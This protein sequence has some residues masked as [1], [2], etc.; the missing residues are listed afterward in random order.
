MGELFLNCIYFIKINDLC[1]MKIKILMKY[2]L[3]V[4]KKKIKLKVGTRLKGNFIT[5]IFF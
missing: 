5:S 1:Y 4:S 3:I 2:Y